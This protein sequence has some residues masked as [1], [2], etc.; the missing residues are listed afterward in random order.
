M[1][2]EIR[3]ERLCLRKQLTNDFEILYK[4]YFSNPAVCQY[5]QRMPHKSARESEEL[6]NK[7][8]NQAWSNHEDSFSWVISLSEN[9]APIGMFT[10]ILEGHKA[11]IHFGISHAYWGKGLMTEG[12]S[13]VIKHLFVY[14]SLERIW[15]L[16]DRDNVSSQKVLLKSGMM[17]EDELKKWLKL[18]YFNHQSRDCLI[19]A[20]TDD[21]FNSVAD[22]Y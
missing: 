2:Q 17:F 16:C 9:R 12:V 7:W 6:L 5:L 18:P 1:K 8:C 15:T 13:A 19:Y 22:Y 11:Q 20:I 14:S 21:L 10:V 3:T 4:K